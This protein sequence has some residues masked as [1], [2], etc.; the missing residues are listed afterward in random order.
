MESTAGLYAAAF[1]GPLLM[2][3]VLTPLALKLALRR[4]ILDHPGDYK[5]QSAAVPYLGGLAIVLSFAVAVLF[6]AFLRPLA[7]FSAQLPL[8]I[9]IGLLLSVVG[10]LDD[11]RGLNPL[12]RFAL[13]VGAAVGLF[14]AGV[15]VE[16]F[17]GN[18]PVNLLVT[19]LWIVGITNA[20][21][22]L[23]NMDGL[24]AGVA[25]IASFGFFL[26]AAL[27]DQYLV[28]ALSL[29]LSGCA[30]GFLRHNVHPARIY[31]GDAGSLFL[32]FMLAVIG[33]KLRFE[34]PPQVTFLVPILVLG[35]PIF[36]TVLVVTTRMMHRL[37]PITGGRDHMSH[38]LVFVGIPV[39]A[40]VSLIYAAAIA[41]GWLAVAMSR[42]D[43]VTAYILAGFVAAVG[44]FLGI[45]L[46]LVPVYETSRRRKVML[47]EV[48]KH[49][50]E[51]GPPSAIVG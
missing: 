19:T 12:L 33:L 9:G 42:V 44:L 6:G 26:I 41:L 36:D 15:R 35:I 8:I 21:N 27:N 40:A 45:L 5:K 7:T 51:A 39:P 18:D 24:S 38:R 16:I 14:A 43:V 28:A 25:V 23:D 11:L 22:L 49:E 34:S 50:E 47:V 17:A 10:L 48:E 2:A 31:M 30:L 4:Q 3:L 20:F 1:A 29:A 13:E 37:S 32:G 46:A